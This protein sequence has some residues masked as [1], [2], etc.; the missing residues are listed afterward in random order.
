MAVA[1]LDDD[2]AL[3]LRIE[4]LNADYIHCIDDDRLEEWPDYF[5]EDGVYRVTTRENADLNMPVSLIFCEGNGMFHDRISALRT[6]NI[7][8]P[9]TYCHS[10]SA[11]QIQKSANGVHTTK[12]NFLITR[13]MSEG[14]MM[15]FACGRYLD[16]IVEQ[17][18]ELK[19]SE[20]TVILESRRIDTLLVIPI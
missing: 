13:T 4:A 20:R 7:F 16:T 9:H 6:A 5:T 3:R 17:D 19:F 12:S 11:L 14:A 18:G 1:E 15:T 2:L 8:E 10:V